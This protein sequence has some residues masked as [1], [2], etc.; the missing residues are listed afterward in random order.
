MQCSATGF[1]AALGRAIYRAV[2]DRTHG[3][4]LLNS[5]GTR[6]GRHAAARR[7]LPLRLFLPAGS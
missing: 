2:A 6:M 3:P 5:R 4:V 1:W 7:L